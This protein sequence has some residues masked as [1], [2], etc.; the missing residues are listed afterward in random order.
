LL[1]ERREHRTGV[2]TWSEW[3]VV[4]VKICNEPIEDLRTA[5]NH[6]DGG[7]SKALQAC[8]NRSGGAT[9]A[10]DDPMAIVPTGFLTQGG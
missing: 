4:V 3:S 7:Q 1:N 10:E 6:R 2:K 5:T 8:S 9:A